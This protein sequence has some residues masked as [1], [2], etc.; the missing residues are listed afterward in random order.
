MYFIGCSLLVTVRKC[1]FKKNDPNIF[2]F[3]T[4]TQLLL[5]FVNKT[6]FFKMKIDLEEY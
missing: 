5:S 3:L 1:T 6:S 4:N 2:A